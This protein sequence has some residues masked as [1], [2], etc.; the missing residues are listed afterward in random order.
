[1]TD[2]IFA[3]D[4]LELRTVDPNWTEE[5][6]LKQKGIFFLKDLV[7][8]LRLDPVRLGK[9]AKR[10]QGKGG[11]PWEVMG[12]RKVWAHWIVKMIKFGPYYL[13]HLKLPFAQL[14]E[15]WTANDLVAPNRTGI[16][17]LTDICK[18]IPF[19]ANQMRYQAKRNPKSKEEMG[20]WKDERLNLFLVNLA[21]FGPWLRITMERLG[22]DNLKD[23]KG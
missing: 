14:P 20:I 2:L 12:L 5:D 15:E 19:S 8:P 9:L 4:E 17:L 22:T 16:F 3:P 7:L 13:E 23:E 1:M 18:K 21:V 10:L 6:L 11:N